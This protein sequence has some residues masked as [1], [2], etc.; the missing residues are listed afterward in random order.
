M[1][2]PASAGRQM[3]TV[4]LP[5][6]DGV[7]RGKVAITAGPMRLS[8]LVRTAYELT[9]ALVARAS[10]LEQE[11]GRTI[12][13]GAGC[14]ACC[15]HMVPV[16]PPEALFIA[17]AIDELE[18]QQRDAVMARIE[19]VVA[20]LE[21]Q[22]LVDEL[23][24]PDATNEPILPA[25]RK[26][27]ELHQACPF[28]VD[29]SCSFYTQRPVACRDYNVTSPAAWCAS[30]YEHDVAKVPMPLPLS[31]PLARLAATVT[32]EKP[33]LLPLTL[34]PR[35]VAAHEHLRARQWSG[36]ELFD[37]FLQEIG[38]AS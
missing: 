26:Y 30:P 36:P 20:T 13:C 25:A 19:R 3:R 7:I 9:D 6:P 31:A 23:L 16:S 8:G 11:A 10:G 27:F 12:S 37:L 33:C 5:V 38:A 32:G 28:L 35:W 24:N 15:R 17:D 14:G 18:P 21:Q 29:E 2:D 34:V 1:A 22:G 4:E